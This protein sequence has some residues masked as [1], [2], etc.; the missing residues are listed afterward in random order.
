MQQAHSHFIVADLFHRL[1]DGFSGAVLLYR[2]LAGMTDPA[3]YLQDLW[4]T[5]LVAGRQHL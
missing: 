2:D 3:A 4:W 5:L 1:S